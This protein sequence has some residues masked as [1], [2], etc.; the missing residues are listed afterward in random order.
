MRHGILHEVKALVVGLIHQCLEESY[1]VLEIIV[2]GGLG[3]FCVVHNLLNR[4]GRIPVM[5]ETPECCSQDS[6]SGRA[7]CRG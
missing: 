5:R 7:V 2:Q 4:G 3:H 6:S 1:F